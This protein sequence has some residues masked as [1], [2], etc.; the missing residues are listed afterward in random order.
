MTPI[1]RLI[2]AVEAGVISTDLITDA[3]GS[4][5]DDVI[6]LAAFDGSLDAARELH[7]ALLPGWRKNLHFTEFFDGSVAISILGPVPDDA[8]KWTF[9][10]K[11]EASASTPARAWLIAI[12]KAY[13]AYM[14]ETD[15]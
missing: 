2:E 9:S 4:G 3:F 8:E 7:D 14:K 5:W 1:D 11:Y 6:I 12:L 13:R 15:K 10:T